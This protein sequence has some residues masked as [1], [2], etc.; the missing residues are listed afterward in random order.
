MKPSTLRA[1]DI[2][3]TQVQDLTEMTEA[4]R[5]ENSRLRAEISSLRTSLADV[6]MRPPAPRPKLRQ[7]LYHGQAV[8]VLDV[9]S[10]IARIVLGE[11]V[12]CVSVD[13]LTPAGGHDQQFGRPAPSPKAG[14]LGVKH[15]AN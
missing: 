15:H 2:I 9:I 3:A 7:A 5:E 13:V 1:L 6:T 12:T 10:G 4:L 14:Q 8:E 11:S